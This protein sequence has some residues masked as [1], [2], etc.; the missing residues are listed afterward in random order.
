M[1]LF[2][3]ETCFFQ[4]SGKKDERAAQQEAKER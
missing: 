1:E 3:V 2:L 4:L